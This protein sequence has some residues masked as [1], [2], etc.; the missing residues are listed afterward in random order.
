MSKEVNVIADAI[1]YAVQNQGQKVRGILLKNGVVVPTGTSDAKLI[2][3]VSDVFK[4]SKPFRNE[5]LKLVATSEY[6]SSSE[7]YSNAFG[8]YALP[9]YNFKPS[10][11]TSLTGASALTND[12]VLNS[13]PTVASDENLWSG[14]KPSTSFW[15]TTN[16]MGLLNKAGD[17]YTT[18]STNKANIAL[19]E[20]A[21]ARAEA[22]IVD[23]S[24]DSN[25]NIGSSNKS[26]TILYLIL[27]IVGI[28][29]IGGLVWYS[30]KSKK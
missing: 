26:N 19:A 27:A 5:F 15:T 30:S 21:K 10:I 11:N 13:V 8:D 25:G 7:N 28:G 22:G 9:S 23:E 3:I 17:V 24:G 4:K 2:L 12:S 20:A 18:T 29:A 16:I 6:V 1:V 14:T